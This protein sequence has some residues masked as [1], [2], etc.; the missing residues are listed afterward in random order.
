M[1]ESSVPALR[2]GFEVLNCYSESR[3]QVSVREMADEI[4][5]PLA[6]TYRLVRELESL[7]VLEASSRGHYRLGLAL[8]RFGNLSLRGRGLREVALP[9][10]HELAENVGETALLLVRVGSQAVCIEHVEGTYP[11]RPRSFGVGERVDLWA[12]AS[13]VALFAFL[14]DHEREQILTEQLGAAGEASHDRVAHIR[15]LCIEVRRQGWCFTRDQ[16]VVGTAAVAAPVFRGNDA[17]VAAL[18]LTGLTERIVDLEDVI[19]EAAMRIGGGL[20]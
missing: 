2:R 8:A 12:G 18:S 6:S 20:A 1:R 17:V 14:P 3:L 13:A 5:A 7:G 19:T 15:D 11:I 10:M 9:V 4:G 16:V